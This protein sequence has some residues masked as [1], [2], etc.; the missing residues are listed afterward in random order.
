MT[1]RFLLVAFAA[2]LAA[3]PGSATST[4]RLECQPMDTWHGLFCNDG[5]DIVYCD[6]GDGNCSVSC[7]QGDVDVTC[8]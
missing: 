2:A 4:S 3:T 8:D 6:D 7:G 1:R 5:G